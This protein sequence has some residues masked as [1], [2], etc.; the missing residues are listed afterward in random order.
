MRERRI[1]HP[2]IAHIDWGSPKQFTR[3]AILSSIPRYNAIENMTHRTSVGEHTMRVISH[4]TNFASIL[5]GRGHLVDISAIW[6]MADNHDNGEAYTGDIP[7]SVKRSATPEQRE[8]MK[9]EERKGVEQ[10]EAMIDMPLSTPRFYPEM[11]D[12]YEDKNTLEARI[13]NFADKW[14]GLHEAV[15]EVVCGENPER[16]KQVISEY[17]DD[18]QN[19][20][21]ANRDWQEEV[22][23][24]LGSD[25]FSFPDPETL[26]PKSIDDTDFTNPT[27]L[28]TS[29]STDNP[30]SYKFWL[31]SNIF[32][33]RV[34][35][36]EN[37]FPGWKDKIPQKVREDIE[38]AKRGDTFRKTSSGL[39]IPSGVHGIPE[40][41]FGD[42]LKNDNWN[43]MLH[44]AGWASAMDEE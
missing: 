38:A 37:V 26:I 10:F 27:T 8:Q 14:D 17:E 23:P 3:A 28:V 7:T 33:F 18:F 2:D 32:A 29:L 31:R 11:Y 4:A 21:D 12:E 43:M 15:H 1:N 19:L 6:F 30:A 35:F 16:F 42:L 44:L 36:I 41:S 13:V 25:F 20:R 40:D 34:Y 5:E 9:V 22:E 39:F 24:V